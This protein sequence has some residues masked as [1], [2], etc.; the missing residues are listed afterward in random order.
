VQ[1][2]TTALR[3][4]KKPFVNVDLSE[5]DHG[6]LCDERASYNA[7]AAREAWALMGAFLREHLG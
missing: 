7:E 1:A 3:E 2:V 4:A 6:F 5:A